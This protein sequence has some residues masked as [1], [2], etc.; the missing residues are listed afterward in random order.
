M[1]RSRLRIIQ[2]RDDFIVNIF[3][4]L[5]LYN[6]HGHLVDPTALAHQKQQEQLKKSAK[7]PQSSSTTTE[8]EREE[9]KILDSSDDEDEDYDDEEQEA[10]DDEDESDVGEKKLKSPS[11]NKLQDEEDVDIEETLITNSFKVDIIV[12]Y[13]NLTQDLVLH[14]GI[15]KKNVGEWN[16]PDDRY[17]PKET[18]RFRDGKAC[19]SKFI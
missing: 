12:E 19:Q 15:S 11:K 5:E 10:N 14:W 13:G 8:R 2:I 18:T 1:M 9:R 16:S 3:V 4:R 17:L 7:Q 6:Q